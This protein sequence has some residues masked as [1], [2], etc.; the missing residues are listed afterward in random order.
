MPAGESDDLAQEQV[1][2]WAKR[3]YYAVRAANDA[4]LRP[5]GLGLTQWAVMEQL[6][7]HGP[8]LQ[9]DIARALEIE[10]ATLSTIVS[11]LVRKGLIAQQ[12]EAGDQR[13]RTLT[14]TAAGDELW[15]AMPDPVASARRIA[16]AGIDPADRAA[17]RRV[18]AQATS[19]LEQHL[20]NPPDRPAT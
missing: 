10:R 14:L 4:T 20:R 9:R 11:T 5:Y 6:A 15:R 17:A 13:Q 1:G 3:F 16:F 19:Q 12:A 8:T 18:L 7:T 2:A